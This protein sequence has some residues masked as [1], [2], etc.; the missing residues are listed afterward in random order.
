MSCQRLKDALNSPAT[1]QPEASLPTTI[2]NNPSKN[3]QCLDS[4]ISEEEASI[5]TKLHSCPRRKGCSRSDYKDL[6][7]RHLVVQI[8]ISHT[9]TQQHFGFYLKLCLKSF[10]NPIPAV[11]VSANVRK[12]KLS[13]FTLPIS[14]GETKIFFMCMR[15]P[16]FSQGWNF[17]VF[18]FIAAVF[19]AHRGKNK[20][21]GKR[22]NL[23]LTGRQDWG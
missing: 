22:D 6:H 2:P 19:F 18:I 7:T 3:R 4:R 13:I 17:T 11:T 16:R 15:I 1:W 8:N 12:A 9:Y 14:Q 5:H 10:K 20:E 21:T 23:P